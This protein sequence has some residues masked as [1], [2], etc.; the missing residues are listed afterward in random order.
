MSVVRKTKLVT[1]IYGKTTDV[2]LDV[3]T[4]EKILEDL[5]E[6]Y[7]IKQ[8]DKAKG[9]TDN[10]IKKGQFIILEDYLKKSKKK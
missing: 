6:L 2:I 8:Y 4:Y 9:K 7:L 1:D 10:E 3:K 5:E